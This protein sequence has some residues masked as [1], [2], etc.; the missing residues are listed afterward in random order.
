MCNGNRASF[1]GLKQPG[2]SVHQPPL[3]SAEDKERVELYLGVHPCHDGKLYGELYL[4]HSRSS[5]LCGY[6]QP[7]DTS[8]IVSPNIQGIAAYCEFLVLY[9]LVL[10]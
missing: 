3:T 10:M 6:I 9:L 2:R 1:P 7:P 5:E 4:Y 8:Y